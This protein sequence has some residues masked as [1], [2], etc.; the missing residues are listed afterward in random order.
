MRK[1]VCVCEKLR[2]ISRTCW[3]GAHTHIHHVT[4]A[5]KRARL[6]FT[7]ILSLGG[8]VRSLLNLL[9]SQLTWC[10]SQ[11]LTASFSSLR[12]QIPVHPPETDEERRWTNAPSCWS[13][14]GPARPPIPRPD[15]FL[16]VFLGVCLFGVRSLLF[17]L[18]DPSPGSVK[19]LGK[20][21][22][23][24]LALGNGRPW[25]GWKLSWQ[26]GQIEGG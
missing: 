23:T 12:G 17:N 25:G 19:Y 3:P 22:E 9:T 16:T 8:A 13:S 24:L 1:S 18:S 10:L 20:P 4:S 6:T 7:P 26:D 5:V 2:E 14:E 11:T 15:I 21:R